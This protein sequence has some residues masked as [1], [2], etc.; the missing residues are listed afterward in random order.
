MLGHQLGRSM[1]QR[2]EAVI[3]SHEIS[4]AIDL[5]HRAASRIAGDRNHALCSDA[6]CRFT[7]F[8]TQ[9]NAQ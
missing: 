9:F 4:F 1:D 5:N 6:G 2:Q 7:G 8:A 3:L